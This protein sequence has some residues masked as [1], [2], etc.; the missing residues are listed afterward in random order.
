MFPV[1]SERDDPVTV[2]ALKYPPPEHLL[3]LSDYR[4]TLC[5]SAAEVV[6]SC[7]SFCDDNGYF[8]DVVLCRGPDMYCCGTP[9]IGELLLEQVAGYR[10]LLPG[11]I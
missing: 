2:L 5:D 1:R 3:P 8:H 4:L 9:I 10:Q 6:G 7:P 11:R